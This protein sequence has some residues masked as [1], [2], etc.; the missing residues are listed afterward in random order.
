[1]MDIYCPRN[2]ESA[3][4]IRETRFLAKKLIFAERDCAKVMRVLYAKKKY[5]SKAA[6]NRIMAA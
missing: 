5:I 2:W 6:Q 1:M 4:G 3:S